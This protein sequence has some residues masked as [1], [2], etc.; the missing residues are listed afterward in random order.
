MHAASAMKCITC[1]PLLYKIFKTE[2]KPLQSN[3]EKTDQ[4][5]ELH[6]TKCVFPVNSG[7]QSDL[8][9]REALKLALS[10]KDAHL[11]LLEHSGIKTLTQAD[12]AKKLKAD[13]K[14]LLD[15]LREEVIWKYNK[16][17]VLLIS[18]ILIVD[19]NIFRMKKVSIWI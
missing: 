19:N 17:F 9:R 8:D 6:Q 4:L 5:Q 7:Q 11:A 3:Q 13:K 14:I 12:Q 10:E 1:K 18:L 15:K 16:S 2:E